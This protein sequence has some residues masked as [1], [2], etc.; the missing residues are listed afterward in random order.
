M[1]EA[2]ALDLGR[3]AIFTLLKIGAPIMLVSLVVGVI[4][5]IVQALT[6]IQEMTLTFVPK[7]VVMFF[8]LM[9]LL[10]FI[11]NELTVFM[12]SVVDRIVNIS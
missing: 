6:Q 5:A 1:N 9:L 12:G 10:P 7:I 4:V 11:L 2:E 8:V 3:E